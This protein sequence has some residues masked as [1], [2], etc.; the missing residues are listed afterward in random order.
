LKKEAALKEQGARKKEGGSKR[1]ARK[2]AAAPAA[3]RPFWLAAVQAA[4]SKQAKDIRALDLREV[5]TFADTLIVCSAAN[6]RQSQAIA[7]EIERVL[8]L[9][10]E[11]PLSVEGYV[12]A[13][14]ILMDYGDYV[15]NIFSEKARAY[16]D[17]ERLWRDA[18][19][20]PQ[21]D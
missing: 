4:A 20:L 13:E 15:V 7:D 21:G 6:V 9:E 16:Y 1:T 17:L 5:A 2:S 10:G 12:N 19:A 3:A 11:R 8:A 18:K 14:W